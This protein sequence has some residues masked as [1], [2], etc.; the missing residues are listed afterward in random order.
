MKRLTWI[1]VLALVVLSI[2]TTGLAQGLTVTASGPSQ[3]DVWGSGFSNVTWVATASSGVA[4][5]TYQWYFGSTPA[6]TG[7]YFPASIWGSNTDETETM[8]MTVVVT[9]HYGQTATASTTTVVY[10]HH[11]ENDCG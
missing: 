3:V 10:R 7:Q 9:D 1:Y 8:V 2:S 6:H 4:P 11:V 5:Y